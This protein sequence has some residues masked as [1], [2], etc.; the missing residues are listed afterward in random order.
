[1]A[2]SPLG[3]AVEPLSQAV[4][5][6]SQ[7]VDPAEPG[8]AGGTSSV[9]QVCERGRHPGEGIRGEVHPLHGAPWAPG[10]LEQLAALPSDHGPEAV[11]V[12]PD[13][14]GVG[15]RQPAGNPRPQDDVPHLED[16]LLT[17]G[18]PAPQDPVEFAAAGE[19][20]PI[21]AP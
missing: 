9:E 14:A 12:H 6:L 18:P 19:T 5:P 16:D 2:G 11:T 21:V 4:E 15:D 7:A 10:D 13:E 20:A 17:L 1:M 8:S 3:R